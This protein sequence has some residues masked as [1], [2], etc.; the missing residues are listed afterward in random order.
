[1]DRTAS[2]DDPL[3]GALLRTPFCNPRL[4]L[5]SKIPCHRLR[6]SVATPTASTGSL[7]AALHAPRVK[8]PTSYQSRAPERRAGR[9]L[10]G[11]FT[12]RSAPEV[13]V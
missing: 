2:V 3:V 10:E 4:V 5:A 8:A 13:S 9:E 12:R 6:Y 11:W 1:M 7:E